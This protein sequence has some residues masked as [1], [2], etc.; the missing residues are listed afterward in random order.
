[1]DEVSRHG[2]LSLRFVLFP[3][4][5]CQCKKRW[6]KLKFGVKLLVHGHCWDQTCFVWV[7]DQV[8]VRLS[9]LSIVHVV[10]VFGPWLSAFYGLCDLWLIQILHYAVPKFKLSSCPLYLIPAL[11]LDRWFFHI[12]LAIIFSCALSH[13]G[14][15]LPFYKQCCSSALIYREFVLLH[16]PVV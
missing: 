3:C 2:F 4:M 8:W 14:E 7:P 1:M 6:R 15:Q 16:P 10:F 12:F 13:L 9:E 5:V 11:Y